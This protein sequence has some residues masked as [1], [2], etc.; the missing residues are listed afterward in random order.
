MKGLLFVMYWRNNN[1]WSIKLE[2]T[3]KNNLT[4]FALL[5]STLVLLSQIN[6]VK[7]TLFI[8]AIIYINTINS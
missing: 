7:Q 5:D 4:F 3:N 2:K 1:D 8:W 6:T